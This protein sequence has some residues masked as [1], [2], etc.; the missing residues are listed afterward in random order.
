MTAAEHSLEHEELMAYLDGELPA[1]KAAIVHAHVAGCA[2]CQRL[3]GELRGLSQDMSL[4]Q[5]EPTPVTLQPPRLSNP[6]ETP[7]ARRFFAWR[8]PASILSFAGAAAVVVLVALVSFSRSP[9]SVRMSLD[10]AQTA[11][12]AVTVQRERQ[13]SPVGTGQEGTVGGPVPPGQLG[14]GAQASQGPMVVRTAKLTILAND[15]DAVRPEVDRILREFS[16]FVGQLDVS[17]TRGASRSLRATLRVPAERLDA[18]LT[19]LKRLG[20]VVEESQGGDDVTEQV[21]DLEARLSNA[22][23]TEKRL[24]D[25]LQKRTGDLADVLAAEREIARVRGEIERFDAERKNIARRVTYATL[26]LEVQEERKAALDLGPLPVSARFR[27][28]LVDG[29]RGAFEGAL[30]IALFAV[31]VGPILLLWALV[32]AWPARA[33]LRWSR[34]NPP[35]PNP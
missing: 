10:E 5:V 8:R 11:G 6:T 29:V 30:E 4:W 17:R 33:F 15:F 25:L 3:S 20:Q 18:A 9:E 23:S 7:A 28:A 16:G 14:R 12:R 26:T 2:L 35:A 1:D 32:L 22:R 19:A 24:S 34:A 21:V 13:P 27:N 31:R